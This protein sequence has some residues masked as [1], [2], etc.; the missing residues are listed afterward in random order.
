MAQNIILNVSPDTLITK[1]GEME[2]QRANTGDLGQRRLQ[3]LSEQIQC[4]L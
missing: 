2:A 4:Q 3:R 1:A